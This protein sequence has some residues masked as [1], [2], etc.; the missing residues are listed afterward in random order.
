MGKRVVFPLDTLRTAAIDIVDLRLQTKGN[1]S[2]GM[3]AMTS[4]V[5]LHRS[6]TLSEKLNLCTRH[7][8]FRRKLR[9]SLWRHKNRISG[10]GAV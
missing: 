10:D 2:D 7:D 1:I 8:V 6:G 5:H 3:A 9:E 4:S